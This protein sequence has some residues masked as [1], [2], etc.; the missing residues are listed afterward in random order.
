MRSSGGVTSSPPLT[1][2]LSFSPTRFC[3]AA[4][5]PISRAGAAAPVANA[6]PSRN[7]SRLL[8]L[9]MLMAG[10]PGTAVQPSGRHIVPVV[11]AARETQFGERSQADRD[12]PG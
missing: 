7:S 3:S 12:D 8:D 4:A 2:S 10:S 5:G 11:A 6:P 9:V 1:R